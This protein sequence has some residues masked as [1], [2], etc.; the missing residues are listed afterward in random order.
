MHVCILLHS[1]LRNC[2][3]LKNF[4]RSSCY[5]V[6]SQ[7]VFPHSLAIHFISL[8]SLSTSR[9]PTLFKVTVHEE[10]KRTLPWRCLLPLSRTSRSKSHLFL[11]WHCTTT[12]SLRPASLAPSRRLRVLLLFLLHL[13]LCRLLLIAA[14]AEDPQREGSGQAGEAQVGPGVVRAEMNS[15]RLIPGY[16]GRLDKTRERLLAPLQEKNS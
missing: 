1:T 12:A 7:S 3:I 15:A 14:L 11:R 4:K 8:L 13:P 16:T 9:C 2:T 10:K 6:F 5:P